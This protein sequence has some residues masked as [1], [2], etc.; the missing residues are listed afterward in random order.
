MIG[1]EAQLWRACPD[2]V[3]PKFDLLSNFVVVLCTFL[4]AR[5][6]AIL[7]E[8]F[9]KRRGF[10]LS[11]GVVNLCE[12]R[13]EH[14]GER[15]PIKNDVM[16]RQIKPMF[17]I[18]KLGDPDPDKGRGGKIEF[19]PCIINGESLRFRLLLFRTE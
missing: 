4:P 1:R 10:A 14:A 16:E 17:A 2:R 8:W 19:S 18:A 7:D 12:F 15:N 11:K 13:Q 6:V 3:P 5:I 9:A